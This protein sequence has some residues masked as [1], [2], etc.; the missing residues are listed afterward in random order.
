MPDKGTIKKVTMVEDGGTS[1]ATT[2]RETKTF[3][4]SDESK[5]KAK[6]LRIFAI[7]SWIV[8]IGFEVG[9]I[10]LLKKTADQYHV[11]HCPDCGGSDFCRCRFAVVE[12]V[13]QI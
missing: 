2:V 12:K 8:A 3:V 4:A 5:A 7:I 13:E 10:F 11:A 1:S 6:S 9:A